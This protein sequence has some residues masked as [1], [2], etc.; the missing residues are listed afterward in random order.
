VLPS[1]LAALALISAETFCNWSSIINNQGVAK[2]LFKTGGANGQSWLGKRRSK[3]DRDPFKRPKA[4]LFLSSFNEPVGTLLTSTRVAIRA[5]WKYGSASLKILDDSKMLYNYFG[6]LHSVRQVRQMS[7]I[8]EIITQIASN[9]GVTDPVV[10][11]EISTA[12]ASRETE[13]NDSETRRFGILRAAQDISRSYNIYEKKVM[14]LAERIW[15]EYNR[16]AVAYDE[17]GHVT[18]AYILKQARALKIPD[19]KALQIAVEIEAKIDS[20]TRQSRIAKLSAEILD[21]KTLPVA[22]RAALL[23]LM[24]AEHKISATQADAIV[25]TIENNH[26]QMKELSR[27][28]TDEYEMFDSPQRRDLYYQAHL[29]MEDVMKTYEL[30]NNIEVDMVT[31]FRQISEWLFRGKYSRRSYMQMAEEIA[32]G[33]SNMPKLSKAI[34]SIFLTSSGITFEEADRRAWTQRESDIRALIA[35]VGL[36]HGLSTI[37]IG[38]LCDG[39]NEN[40]GGSKEIRKPGIIDNLKENR[41]E[42]KAATLELCQYLA[43]KMASGLTAT[44]ALKIYMEEK[45]FFGLFGY[46]RG[47]K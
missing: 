36:S 47:K 4:A 22:D 11:H 8:K 9:A 41:E 18:A 46:P 42:R 21:G 45:G 17:P 6:I 31:K 1:Y 30:D 24:R 34:E 12:L 16:S 7:A 44:Q 14:R 43:E 40:L 28:L 27:S 25:K 29:I 32:A 20:L 19:E 38:R 33:I 39:I 35:T 26:Q 2:A 5:V 23:D 13:L 10:C 37:E 3:L 15:E